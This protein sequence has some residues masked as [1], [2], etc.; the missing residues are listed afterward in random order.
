MYLHAAGKFQGP[1]P[2]EVQQQ[3]QHAYAHRS[4]DRSQRDRR[5]RRSFRRIYSIYAT[6]ASSSTVDESGAPH[7]AALPVPEYL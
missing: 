7:P 3:Q 4:I 5:G 2:R 1:G 6:R